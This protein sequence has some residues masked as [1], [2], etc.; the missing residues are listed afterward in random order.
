MKRVEL[1]VGKELQ[2]ERQQWFRSLALLSCVQSALI[3]AY[4]STAESMASIWI[5]SGTFSH[6]FVVLPLAVWMIWERKHELSR[7]RTEPSL[8]PLIPILFAGLAWLS[9]ALVDILVVQQ[10]AFVAV[11]AF[12]TWGVLGNQIARRIVFPLGFLFFMVPA[13]EV[14]V[15][16]LME[17]TAS[18]TVWLIQLTGI[19]VYREGMYLM[20]PTG[21][22]SVVE[23]CSGFR[24]LIAS[25]T[26]GSVYAY[27]NYST[28]SKR[29]Y[30]ILL[31]ILVPIVANNLRAYGIVMIGHLS[32]MKLA[33]GVDHLLYGWVFFGF[34][35]A[36]MFWIGSYFRDDEIASPGKDQK[37]ASVEFEVISPAKTFFWSSVQKLAL[38]AV[39]A[40]V[41]PVWFSSLEKDIKP[42]LEVTLQAPEVPHQWKQIRDHQA[43]WDSRLKGATTSIRAA[44]F[45]NGSVGDEGPFE[46]FIE[47]LHTQEQGREV[48]NK[49]L[50]MLKDNKAWVQIHRGSSTIKKGSS[51]I[52][53]ERTR[54]VRGNQEWVV[55]GVYRIADSYTVDVYEAKLLGIFSKLLSQR[56]DG[57]RILFTA[58]ASLEF[59]LKQWMASSL[60]SIE[61]QLEEIYERQV[62]ERQQ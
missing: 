25:V 60:P 14:L 37:E 27:L 33:T 62:E 50:V 20:L 41:W 42:D 53:V 19:P 51:T 18:T 58:P 44:Y 30:F 23:A 29:F 34:V 2:M 47:Y 24:Y 36:I 15:G 3:L 61:S 22:W 11:S 57:A 9:A 54:L 7:L 28:V 35:M 5:R 13:G 43:V 32:D 10:F 31:S 45:D 39:V 4:F 1:I 21:N 6:C 56:D 17:L 48:V 49:H 40:L 26:L 12:L 38:L 16:P 52:D 59:E 55:L 46:V 8:F